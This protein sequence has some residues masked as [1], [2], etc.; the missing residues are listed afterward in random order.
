MITSGVVDKSNY[1]YQLYDEDNDEENKLLIQVNDIKPKFLSGYTILS[2]HN[3]KI[4]IVKDPLSD[5]SLWQKEEV[6]F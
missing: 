1:N 6:I 4:E 5:I 3:L 2:N